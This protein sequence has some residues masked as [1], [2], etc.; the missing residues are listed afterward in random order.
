MAFV[1]DEKIQQTATAYALDAI[2]FA[3]DYFQ[4]TLDWSDESV[5][6]VESILD[7]FHRDLPTANP[8]EQTIYQFAKMFG[9]Y[10]GEV[11][12]R[13]HAAQWGLVTAGGE[14]FPGM[15]SKHMDLEFWPWGKVHCRLRDGP[16]HDIWFY[17][18]ILAAD[19]EAEP[20]DP[21][22]AS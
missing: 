16:E 11:L 8:S 18:H 14:T 19:D 4:I 2:D 7:R 6:Y 13:N 20:G 9:S 12:R 5:R 1:Q 3:Q 17:F 22:G 15:Y 21:E 10:V